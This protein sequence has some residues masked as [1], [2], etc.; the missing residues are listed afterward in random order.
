MQTPIVYGDQLYTC[1]D[2][3][4][5][6]AYEAKTGEQRFRTRIGDGATGFTASAVA[7]DG[8]LYYTGEEGDVFVV[9][10]GPTADLLATNSMNEVCMATPAIS[11]GRLFIRT[12]HHVYCVGD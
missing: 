12:Q 4:I 5:F 8:K 3:G 2:N 7:A 9:Q 6:T 11:D 10:A 1:T